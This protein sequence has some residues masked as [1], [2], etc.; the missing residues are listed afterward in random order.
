MKQR[1][2]WHRSARWLA[3]LGFLAFAAFVI[4]RSFEVAGYQCTVCMAFG[5]GSICRTVEAATAHEA[6]AGAVNNACAFLASGV[7]DS[8]ACERTAPTRDDCRALN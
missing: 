6:R 4:S 1:T 3:V 2:S 8:M 7:T 5:G